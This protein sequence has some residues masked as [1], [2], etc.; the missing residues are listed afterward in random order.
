MPGTIGHRQADKMH[1]QQSHG[2][3]EPVELVD[4]VLKARQAQ[5]TDG[6]HDRHENDYVELVDQRVV[7]PGH[8]EAKDTKAVTVRATRSVG[9]LHG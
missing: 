6:Q 4:M 8:K 3:R 7:F 9:T 5:Y 2:C 1:R